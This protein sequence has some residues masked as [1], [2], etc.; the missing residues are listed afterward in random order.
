M[1]KFVVIPQLVDDEDHE[2]AVVVIKPAA[3]DEWSGE[4][5]DDEVK[6]GKPAVMR[7][8]FRLSLIA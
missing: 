3:T 2:E 8:L 7:N 1:C 6:V 4:D 5:E